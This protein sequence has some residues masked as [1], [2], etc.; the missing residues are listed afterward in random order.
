MKKKKKKRKKGISID[1]YIY[2]DKFKFLK[3]I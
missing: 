2:V 1:N 3:Y